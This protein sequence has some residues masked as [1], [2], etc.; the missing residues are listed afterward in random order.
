MARLVAAGADEQ[1]LPV[2][3]RAIGGPDLRAVDHQRVAVDLCAGAQ[4]GEVG[5]GARLGEALAPH[6]IAPEDGRQMA[7][8]LRLV[9]LHDQRGAAM[10]EADEHRPARRRAS[11]AIFLVP[12]HLADQRQPA[13]AIFDRPRDP[14]PA[15]V[16]LA[17]LPGGIVI[18]QRPALARPRLARHIVGEPVAHLL[19][20]PRLLGGFDDPHAGR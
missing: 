20:E 13:P 15:G 6:L 9:A 17:A 2:C 10:A 14:G 7:R 16:I 4:R 3:D 12:D 1:L 5:P 8:F 19:A 11:A 18:A